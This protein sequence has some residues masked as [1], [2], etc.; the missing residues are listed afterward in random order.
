MLSSA[1]I[2]VSVKTNYRIE[3]TVLYI[4]FFTTCRK[5]SWNSMKLTEMWKVKTP[6]NGENM[7]ILFD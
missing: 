2:S 5:I 3:I 6:T 7:T 1:Y 4:A